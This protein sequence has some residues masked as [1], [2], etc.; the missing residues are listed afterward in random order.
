MSGAIELR[1]IA[2]LPMPKSL[3]KKKADEAQKGLIRPIKKPDLSNLAKHLEDCMTKI[4]FW[5]DDAQICRVC[6]EKRYEDIAGPRW[7]IAIYADVRG[8]ILI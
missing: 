2:Y 1:F 4:G 8:R 3:S 5:N 7:E 6:M